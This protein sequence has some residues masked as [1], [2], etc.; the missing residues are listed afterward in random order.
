MSGTD[1]LIDLL[2][3]DARPVRRLA[4]PWRR[5]L[6][7]DAVLLLAALLLVWALGGLGGLRIRMGSPYLAAETLGAIATSMT[8]LLAA[9]QLN[10]PGRSPRW[11]LLPVVP[12]LVWL[13]GSLSGCLHA[14]SGGIALQPGAGM[15][16]FVF[17]AG[18]GIPLA[19][20]VFV[21]LR[22]G[23]ALQPIRIAALGGLAA[24]SLA[25]VVLHGPHFLE[26]NLTDS[27]MH[28][29]AVLLVVAIATAFGRPALRA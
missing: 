27:A 7:W 8:A 14:A 24:A 5:W 12:A 4:S 19:A 11:A 18:L 3:A 10:V 17:I 20:I 13:G 6:V 23:A 22:R 1:S 28:T 26:G 15:H 25:T 29:A 9:F 16:C 2:A 21:L